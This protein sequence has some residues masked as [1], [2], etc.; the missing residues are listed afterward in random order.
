MAASIR[1][2]K[3]ADRA[4]CNS[5]SSF[6]SDRNPSTPS[7]CLLA[8]EPPTGAAQLF[9]VSNR[10]WNSQIDLRAGAGAAPDIERSPN[11]S[12]AFTHPRQT[13]VPGAAR[14]QDLRRDAA[15]VIPDSQPQQPFVIGNFHFDVLCPGVDE[16][17]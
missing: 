6:C 13:V 11:L 15:S 3:S 10:A 1:S 8:E 4:P 17:I 7:Y 2:I 9:T 5:P 16:S 12:S 14:F